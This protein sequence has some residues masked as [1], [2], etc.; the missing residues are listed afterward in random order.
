[1]QVYVRGEGIVVDQPALV[2]LDRLSSEILTFGDQ[3]VELF[4]R[5]PDTVRLAGPADPA[6]RERM[7]QHLIGRTQGRQRLF[8]PEVMICIHSTATG[9]ERRALAEAA[10]AAGARQAWLLEAPLAAAMGAGLPVTESRPHA[11]CD[12]GA[13]TTEAAVVALSGLVVAHAAPGGGR[14][15]D[16]AI[17]ERL[18]ERR[19]LVVDQRGAETLK[20]AIGAATPGAEPAPSAQVTATDA[21]TGELVQ[22]AVGAAEVADAI[23]EPVGRICAAVRR[24]LDQTPSRLLADVLADGLVLTGGGARL[25]GLPERL[26]RDAGI[27]ARVADEPQTCVVRGTRRALGQ[28][29]VIQ[30]RQLFF[31]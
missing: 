19:G 2:A 14:D 21:G 15:L 6:V 7:L 29:E 22:A 27:R 24:T 13:T 31:R 5:E 26:E 8:R 1:V 4:E 28:Y 18:R 20:I 17:V 3:A 12:V 10:I 23:R 9:D 25:A 11:I 30:R 16:S